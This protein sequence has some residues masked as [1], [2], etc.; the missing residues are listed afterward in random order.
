MLV[1][2][3]SKEE[4]R[5]SKKLPYTVIQADNSA[6]VVKDDVTGIT[7]YISYKGYASSATLVADSE[8]ETIVMERTK[9]DGSVVM[10]I[11]TPD[12]GITEK[13]Y[14]TTQPS[15][16]IV[17]TVILNGRWSLSSPA[18]NV[19]VMQEGGNTAVVATCV[20]GQPVEF[21]LNNN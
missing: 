15:Q 13:G 19:K 17:K 2:P 4:G 21:E 20:H 9:D 12:L 10:S 1:K 16:P 14:T 5:Y 6:H 11:C 3:S 18:D 8:S 7:A